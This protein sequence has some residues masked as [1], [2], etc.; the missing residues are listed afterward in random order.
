MAKRKS[1]TLSDAEAYELLEQM[2]AA[3]ALFTFEQIDEMEK[4]INE[5]GWVRR[6]GHALLMKT[7]G[8]LLNQFE[9]DR[10]AAVTFVCWYDQTER[11]IKMLDSLKELAE[12]ARSRALMAYAQRED[13]DAVFAEGRAEANAA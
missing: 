11:Y 5:L 10:D 8:E 2:K 1:T 3:P 9:K 7:G 4:V 6:A 13:M 12:V